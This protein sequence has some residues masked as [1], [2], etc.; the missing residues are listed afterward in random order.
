[1]NAEIAGSQLSLAETAGLSNPK[2]V[3]QDYKEYDSDAKKELKEM[4]DS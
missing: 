4:A 1:M 3:L 2:S